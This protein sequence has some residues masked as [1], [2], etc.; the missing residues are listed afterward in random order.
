MQQPSRSNDSLPQALRY[1]FS[2]KSVGQ[3]RSDAMNVLLIGYGYVGSYLYPLLLEAGHNVVVCDRDSKFVTDVMDALPCAYQELTAKDFREFDTILWFAGHSSVPMAL[4]DPGGAVSNNCLDLL[5]LARRKATRTKLIYASTASVYSVE[6]SDLPG[7][8]PPEMTESET[9][10]SP[11]NPYDCSKISF[12]ALARCFATNV[13]GLRLGTVCGNSPKLREELIFNAMNIAAM[14]KGCVP[15]ANAFSWRNILF[16]DDLARYIISL[17]ESQRDLPQIINAGSQNVSVGDLADQISKFYGVP[18][19]TRP[20]T[21]TYSFKM[22]CEKLWSICGRPRVV[23]I[24]RR[25][26]EFATNYP[27]FQVGLAS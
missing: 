7:R 2:L 19:V 13:V 8:Q 18:V 12:D 16:L 1:S 20:D 21:K 4:E 15:V 6:A 17:I 10:L 26:E 22:N 9:R 11:V 25:C 24:A 5:S 14:T 23:S 3:L 27:T